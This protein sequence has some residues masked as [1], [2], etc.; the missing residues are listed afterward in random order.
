M[1][2][3]AIIG[4]G[5][6]GS[7]VA[8]RLASTGRHEVILCARRALPG[9]TVETSNGTLTV[10]PTVLTRPAD[11]TAVDWVLV[12]TKTYDAD[13]AA[14]W[15]GGL[16][17]ANTSV[18]ILQNGVE[19]RERFA[20]HL[21]AAQIVPVIVDVP[22]E[23]LEP[24]RVREHRRGLLTVADDARGREFAALFAGAAI[25]VVLTA[26]WP[27][28]AWRKLCLNAA[29]VL[30]AVLL[31]PAGVMHDEATGEICRE[32]V[33]ECIAVGRAE[34]AVLEDELAGDVLRAY[35]AAPPHA[36]NSLHADR[37]AGRPMETDAR[38]GVI[39]RLGRQHGIATPCNQMAVALL[40]A[41]S[42]PGA[43]SH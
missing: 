35:R 36:V 18:A 38:N 39:V 6:V 41:M 21:A 14:A 17:R 40:G 31:Q 37:L 15:F 20:R 5:A 26:D 13:G 22:S 27:S 8:A 28:A 24:G 1:A 10:R 42:K 33:R 3:I 29:G 11:A 34:G 23:R 12:T 2:R 7:V 19:H 4:P 25:D 16:A 32:L 43:P 9:L 30:N